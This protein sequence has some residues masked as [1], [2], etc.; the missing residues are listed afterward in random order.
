MVS[1]QQQ[2]TGDIIG[3]NTS[4]SPSSP[5]VVL[6]T[7]EDAVQLLSSS[8]TGLF[9]APLEEISD[10][11]TELQYVCCGDCDHGC[12]GSDAACCLLVA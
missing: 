4:T 7:G 9:G 2:S 8:F 1:I 5:T 6:S 11:L 3:S 10:K 12:G